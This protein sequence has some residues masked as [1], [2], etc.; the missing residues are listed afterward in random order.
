MKFMEVRRRFEMGD[1]IRVLFSNVQVTRDS[2]TDSV[3]AFL[4]QHSH[5]HPA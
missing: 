5:P 4:M 1:T 3:A 2:I